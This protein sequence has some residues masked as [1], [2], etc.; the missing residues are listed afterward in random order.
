MNPFRDSWFGRLRRSFSAVGVKRKGE[1]LKEEGATGK[2]SHC[3]SLSVKTK[4]VH[5]RG[6]APSQLSPTA[7]DTTNQKVGGWLRMRRALPELE[8]RD[9]RTK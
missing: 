6:G 3:A 2:N 7:G 1:T 9:R 4:L 5:A 8:E